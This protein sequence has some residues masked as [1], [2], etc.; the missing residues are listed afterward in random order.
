VVHWLPVVPVEL[1]VAPVVFLHKPFLAHVYNTV[2]AC[3]FA[4]GSVCTCICL[5]HLWAMATRFKISKCISP[6]CCEWCCRLA[7]VYFGMPMYTLGQWSPPVCCGCA[8]V[9]DALI[10]YTEK[11]NNDW[12]QY[13]VDV[14]R[15][16][17][18][19][20]SQCAGTWF[21]LGGWWGWY[22]VF[23]CQSVRPVSGLYWPSAHSHF[24]GSVPYV[25]RPPALRR[26]V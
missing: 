5:S 20:R 17:I 24:N 4:T 3:D 23:T 8:G 13:M 14:A 2:R 12:H 25:T 9:A 16:G 11:W 15:V 1:P 22:V 7:R 18:R 19:S 26:L 21:I 10:I 6:H